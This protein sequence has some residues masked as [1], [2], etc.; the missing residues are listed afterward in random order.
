[1]T[2]DESD[3]GCSVP[4]SDAVL[5]TPRGHPQKRSPPTSM[6]DGNEEA[7]CNKADYDGEDGRTVSASKRRRSADVEVHILA[8]DCSITLIVTTA[9]ELMC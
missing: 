3:P 6:F 5:S 8:N 9:V 4:L 2:I 7:E 1:V